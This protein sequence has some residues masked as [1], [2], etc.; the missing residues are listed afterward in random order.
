[1]A[2]FPLLK[3]ET[4]LGAVTLYSSDL[5]EYTGDHERRLEEASGLLA[6]AL[7]S[8]PAIAKAPASETALKEIGI[9][10]SSLSHNE[11]ELQSDFA[12]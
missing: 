10:D 2:V 4:V 12:H 11:L 5:A 8:K 7:A 3:D 1:L 6:A 9:P